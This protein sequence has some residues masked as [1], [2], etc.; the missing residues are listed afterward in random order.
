VETQTAATSNEGEWL[1]ITPDGYYQASPWG[2]RYINVRVNN[3]VSGIDSY[4]SVFYNPDVVQARLAG[5]PDPASKANVTIQQV[6]A[7]TPPQV[8]IQSPANFSTT[9]T[10]TAN[11]SVSV[12][13][14]NQPIRNIKILV[15]GRLVGRNELSAIKGSR[16]LQP[17]K[18]SLTV[19]GNQRTLDFNLPVNLDPGRNII[20][21]V[22]FNGYSESSRIPVEVTWNAPAGQRPPLPNLWIL[23]V[24]VNNYNDSAIRNLN[25]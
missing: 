24:G 13:D 9:N 14:Q 6:A 20:E 10:A 18:A 8:T 7:F 16:G 19:T 2:D 17:Q 4:R 11:L 1:S 23:A 12:V 15:N 3:T 5:R 22:A 21:V 25:G